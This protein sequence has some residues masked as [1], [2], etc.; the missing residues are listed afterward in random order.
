[1]PIY[2][3]QHQHEKPTS[4]L[5]KSS[6]ENKQQIILKIH[7][8]SHQKWAWQS[9]MNNEGYDTEMLATTIHC[10]FNE[11]NLKTITKIVF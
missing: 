10:T 3:L 2:A 8:F 11:N 9:T 6:G 4:L 7:I 5:C 1:M